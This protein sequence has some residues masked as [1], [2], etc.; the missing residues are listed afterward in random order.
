[1]ILS[2]V[3]D[4]S[5]VTT[6]WQVCSPNH[7]T[8]GGSL[9]GHRLIRYLH[10][11]VPQPAPSGPTSRQG[12]RVRGLDKAVMEPLACWATKGDPGM[13]R[14]SSRSDMK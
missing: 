7:K 11:E 12:E 13:R 9:S 6:I 1:M 5:V 8:P 14:A 4:T 2:P 3:R 10:C